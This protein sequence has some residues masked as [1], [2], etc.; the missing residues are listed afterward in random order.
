MTCPEIPELAPLY[1]AGELDAARA[2]AFADHLRGCPACRQELAEE[3]AFDKRLRSAILSQPVDTSAVDQRI[4]DIIHAPA[5]YRW[6][7]FAAGIAALLLL[8]SVGYFELRSRGV[9]P[10]AIAAAT[11]YRMEIADHQ[12]RPWITNRDAIEALASKQSLPV[13]AI[14]SLT[15]AGYHFVKGKLCYL[16]GNW[17]LHLVY[18]NALGDASVYL[19]RVDLFASS[20]IRVDKIAAEHV[21]AF[22][23]G[24][25]STLVV[26]SQ[27]GEAARR[28]AESAAALI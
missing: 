23:H 8:A 1:L 28:L 20:G 4:R 16:D 13:S 14:S 11:D 17:Y 3:S 5:Q 24:R 25:L 27:P 2:A 15:P 18:G 10:V 22:Q 12:P 6:N 9:S 26:T 21:A 7:H 19:R